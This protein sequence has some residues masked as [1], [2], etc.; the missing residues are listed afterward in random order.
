LFYPLFLCTRGK[1][2]LCCGRFKKNFH[3]F[4]CFFEWPLFASSFCQKESRDFISV[5]AK[6]NRILVKVKKGQNSTLWRVVIRKRETH[7][8]DQANRPTRRRSAVGWPGSAFSYSRTSKSIFG[9]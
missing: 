2:G 8:L 1:K 6:I 7:I 5:T 4:F 3:D 9:P